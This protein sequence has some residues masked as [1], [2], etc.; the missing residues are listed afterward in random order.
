MTCMKYFLMSVLIFSSVLARAEVLIHFKSGRERSMQELIAA[1]KTLLYI[2]KDCGAC[3]RYLKDL[4]KCP[5]EITEKIIL[6]SVSTPVQTKEMMSALPQNRDVYIFKSKKAI[7]SLRATPTTQARPGK[8]I[9]ILS[10]Q[11]LK[12]WQET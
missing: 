12:E 2:E 4:R 5:P 1:G 7:K 3:R 10:C 6:V 9:G 11:E 8:K